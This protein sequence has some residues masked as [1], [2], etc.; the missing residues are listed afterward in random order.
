MGRGFEKKSYETVHWIEFLLCY[1]FA[2]SSPCTSG[3]L[4]LRCSRLTLSFCGRLP[5]YLS[6]EASQVIFPA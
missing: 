4:E 1:Y 6:F 5:A 3:T 2:S